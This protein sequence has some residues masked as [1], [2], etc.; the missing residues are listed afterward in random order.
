MYNSIECGKFMAYVKK[1][2]K[3]KMHVDTV[4][5]NVKS[6]FNNTLVSVTTLAGDVLMRCSAGMLNYKGTRKSTPYAATQVGAALAKDMQAI[7]VKTVEINMQGMGNSRDGV[8]RSMQGAGFDVAVLRD[9]TS[10]AHG[11][12]RP[13]KRRRT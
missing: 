4:R 3:H 9:V 6:T 5:V 1:V 11:G 12:C 2:K 7:G 8:V 13:R 10:L